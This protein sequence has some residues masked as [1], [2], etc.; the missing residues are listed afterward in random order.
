MTVSSEPREYTVNSSGVLTCTA[1]FGGPERGSLSTY[2]QLRM[3]IAGSLIDDEMAPLDYTYE[4]P[5]HYMVRV[6]VT[7]Y[8]FSV[9][10][11]R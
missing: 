7:Q 9:V 10:K 3:M 11:S 4:P 2:P 1:T 5:M 6:C 8:T